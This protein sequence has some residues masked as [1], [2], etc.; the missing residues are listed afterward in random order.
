MTEDIVHE[1]TYPYPPDEVWR[2]I[3]EQA[4]LSGWLMQ[5]NFGQPQVGHKFEFR[6]KPRL[7]WSGVTDCEVLE[8]VPNRRLMFSFRAREEK[9]EPTFVSFDL[10]P[11]AQGT[12]LRFRH[13][14]FGG[15]KGWIMRQGMNHGWARM[16]ARGIPFVLERRRATGAWPPRDEVKAHAKARAAPAR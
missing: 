12:R 8:A 15:V 3:T 9:G 11:V 2:A 7:N 10:E 13:W 14:G 16:V 4:A 6:D 1:A 5:T